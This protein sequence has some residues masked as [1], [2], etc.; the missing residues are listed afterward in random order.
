M[1][2]LKMFDPKKEDRNLKENNISEKNRILDDISK[3]FS[4]ILADSNILK[5]NNKIFEEALMDKNVLGF[6]QDIYNQIHPFKIDQKFYIITAGNFIDFLNE[7]KKDA[8]KHLKIW[9]IYT[10]ETS[11]LKLRFAGLNHY[12]K[13]YAD[14]CIDQLALGDATEK[15]SP[16]KDRD[17]ELEFKYETAE[18]KKGLQLKEER[19]SDDDGS[20]YDSG[21]IKKY[22]NPDGKVARLETSRSSSIH[23]E[24][25][26]NDDSIIE[27]SY[28]QKSEPVEIVFSNY[29]NGDIDNGCDLWTSSLK[30]KAN[31]IYSSDRLEKVIVI[32]NHHDWSESSDD[33]RLQ[34]D[35]GLKYRIEREYIIT[36]DIQ[37][38]LES[39]KEI[40]NNSKDN[41][42]TE[43]AIYHI[44]DLNNH[45]YENMKPNEIIM[46]D[47][48]YRDYSQLV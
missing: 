26:Q 43:Q 3:H 17:E 6:I 9:D 15:K 25:S 8:D 41:S 45:L 38:V 18:S 13:K 10:P 16:A 19:W 23:N 4:D 20:Y 42:T 37:G 30:G 48:F 1:N 32:E 33:L 39:I 29:S 40:T 11:K 5:N 35:D 12:L 47:L 27:L 2:E 44:D 36:Y 14:R 31:F 28:G 7:L 46:R 24:S 34:K 21:D 22:S